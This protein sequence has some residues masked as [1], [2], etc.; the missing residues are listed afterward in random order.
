MANN[1]LFILC[2]Q[3]DEMGLF[4]R[5]KSS[6]EQKKNVLI[7][8]MTSG[9][10]ISIPKKKNTRR[11]IESISVLKKLGV[12]E[13]NIFFIGIKNNIKIYELYLHLDKS[14][15]DLVLIIRKLKGN[16]I[17]F[18]HTW[19]GG[20]EDHD[21]CHSIV[22][23]LYSQIKKIKKCYQFSLYHGKNTP[24][25]FFKVQ[26]L[27]RKNGKIIKDKI[28]TYNKLI[29]LKY[30]FYYKSQ[31]KVWIGLYPFLIKNILFNKYGFLQI[32]KKNMKLKKPHKDKLL[33]E[34]MRDNKYSNIISHIN[35]FLL[36]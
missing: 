9:Y 26:D 36:K 13:K 7:I 25:N 8:F 2:H 4:N 15:K 18:T 30:L 24:F 16:T 32:I 19:E 14:Y 11:D 27:F 20:N 21:A 10:D 34:R 35:L 22:L 23:K 28:S 3:D 31:Y 12:K 1:I 17:I 5:I 6:V 33:Y 29:F